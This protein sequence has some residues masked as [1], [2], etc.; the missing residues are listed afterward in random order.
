MRV[1]T[2]DLRFGLYTETGGWPGNDGCLEFHQGTS[3]SE[4]ERRPQSLHDRVKT[5]NPQSHTPKRL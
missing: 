1:E 2:N 5:P 3:H 4:P